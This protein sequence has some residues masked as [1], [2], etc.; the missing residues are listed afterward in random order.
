MA[1][2]DLVALVAEL[3]EHLVATQER[4]VE[5]EASRWIGEAEA[6]AADLAGEDVDPDVVRERIGHVREL[7]GHVDGTGDPTADEHVAAARDLADDLLERLDYS[8]A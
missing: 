7:L 4:P 6:V 3:H 8:S 5:R 1:D 2:A